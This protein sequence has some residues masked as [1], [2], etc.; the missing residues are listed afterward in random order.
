MTVNTNITFKASNGKY[1]LC[2]TETH[3]EYKNLVQWLHLVLWYEFYLYGGF[4]LI[5]EWCAWTY[6]YYAE[7]YLKS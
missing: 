6:L 4:A 2:K 7:I 1:N 5:K 3:L